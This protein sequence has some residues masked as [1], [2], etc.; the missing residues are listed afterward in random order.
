M[1]YNSCLLVCR[2]YHQTFQEEN[3]YEEEVN[4]Q[5]VI[6]ILMED[7]RVVVGLEDL[8][9][10]ICVFLQ[11]YPEVVDEVV[12]TLRIVVLGELCSRLFVRHRVVLHAC[13]R[14]RFLL[15]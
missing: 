15:L 9:Y 12:E 1:D 8:V 14:L 2:N 4:V 10:R 5:A 6:D 11:I 13:A 3:V 7:R